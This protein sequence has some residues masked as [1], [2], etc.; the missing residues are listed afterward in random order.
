MSTL[1]IVLGMEMFWGLLV[2]Y[3]ASMGKALGSV[4]SKGWEVL[5]VYTKWRLEST[6]SVVLRFKCSF[7]S[8]ATAKKDKMLLCMGRSTLLGIKSRRETKTGLIFLA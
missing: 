7:V 4:P 5:M 1:W 6:A 8:K 2:Q 3:L